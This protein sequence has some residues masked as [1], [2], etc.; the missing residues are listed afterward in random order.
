MEDHLKGGTQGPC[1]S[2]KIC[3]IIYSFRL[4]I[5]LLPLFFVSSPV[6]KVA[7]VFVKNVTR[8]DVSRVPT[9]TGKM[10]KHFPVRE[11]S[12]NFEQTGKVGKSHKILEFEINII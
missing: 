7:G 5:G 8:R 2:P 3:R 6:V 1:P 10:G 12:G 4:N 11:K 9:R